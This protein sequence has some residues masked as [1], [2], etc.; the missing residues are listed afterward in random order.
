KYLTLNKNELIYLSMLLEDPLLKSI[1]DVYKLRTYIFDAYYTGYLEEFKALN[2]KDLYVFDDYL[3][4]SEKIN[5]LI[6]EKRQISKESFEMELYKN[7]LNFAN[8]KRIMDIKRVLE[9]VNKPSIR[10]FINTFQPE[11]FE[12]VKIWM[13]TP[14]VVS[15][16]IPL[17]YGMFDLVIFDEASQMY[18]EKGI[19]AIYRAKKVVIAGDPKQLRPSSLGIGRIEEEDDLYENDILKDVT[20]DAKSLLD[21]ARYKYHETILNYHYRSNYEE[22]IAFSN[23]AFY[24]NK[25]IVSPNVS[26]GDK[27]PIE[28]VYVEEGR[29]SKRQNEAE[30]RKVVEI[31]KKVFRERK[32]NETIGVITFNSAQRDLIENYIDEEIFKRSRYQ[33]EFEEELFRRDNDEDKSLFVKNIENV[34][35]DERDIIIFSMGYAKDHSGALMRRFGWLNHSGG[36]N[37]LNVA[38]TRAKDKIYFVSSLY[39]EEFKVED[40]K[41]YG[42]KLLKDFMRYCY[43]ISNG[44]KEMAKVVLNELHATEKVSKTV[45]TNKLVD[46]VEQKLSRFNYRIDRNI[47]IGTEQIDL[48]LFDELNNKYVLGIICDVDSS[49]RR[50]NAR[51]DLIHQERY[52]KAR[53][54]EV[55]R[56]LSKNWYSDNNKEIKNIRDI[57]KKAN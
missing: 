16:I 51:K 49:D 47:G 12:N 38:I 40:L 10:N 45:L 15:T 26:F 27:S 55:Y 11:M 20:I 46:E 54:W 21:L 18:V 32:N 7:A 30:A 13:M 9:S 6:D 41:S 37:R 57:L 33:K 42:P 34:Q 36:Q 56:I 17:E 2:Q 35:G 3:K 14:E 29:F 48:A 31:I 4:T 25:L 52:L 24:D 1:N 39:P 5:S 44:N 23:A 28:Y 8:S 19:P 50:I 22:L 43:F 53:S